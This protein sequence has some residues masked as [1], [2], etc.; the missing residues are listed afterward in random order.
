MKLKSI[1]IIILAVVL[2]I[3]VGLTITVITIATRYEKG[4]KALSIQNVDV[5]TLNDG[6]YQGKYSLL[7]VMASV[8]V[9]VAKG[10][11]ASIDL[12]SHF[13]GKGYSGEKIIGRIIEKQS[14]QVDAVA[15]STGSSKVILKAVEKALLSHK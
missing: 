3:I 12:L 5:S 4:I 7:P 10:K 14:L 8:K 13:H 6:T 1:L 9:T 2:V 11:I 15:G